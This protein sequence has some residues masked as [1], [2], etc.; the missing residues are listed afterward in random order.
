MGMAGLSMSPAYGVYR[1]F[2]RLIDWIYPP[3]CAGCS[4]IGV[5]W[6]NDCIKGV[7]KIDNNIC[8]ICGSPQLG[9][10]LCNNCGGVTQNYEAIRSWG[11]FDGGLRIAIHQLKYEQNIGLGES[12]SIH[13]INK[14]LK[15]DWTIDL[16][17][18][19]PLSP[20]RLRERGYNQSRLLSKPLSL[21]TGIALSSKSLLRVKETRSQV[22]LNFQER[23]KN[24][25]GAFWADSSLV[26]HKNILV[27]D[28]LT[29]TGATI[30]S[31]ANALKESGCASVYGLTLARPLL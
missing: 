9:D 1:F 15:Q 3:H 24:V 25:E 2:W 17:V 26:S 12:L 7:I 27:I 10:W 11:I 8:H 18:P 6:C 20:N 31:C 22:G 14:L 23:I 29:T 5:R 13:L 16:I 19:V 28:D 21:A 30:K 4:K